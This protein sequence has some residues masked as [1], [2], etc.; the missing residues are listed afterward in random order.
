MPRRPRS[1][2]AERMRSAGVEPPATAISAPA[3]RSALT[4]AESASGAVTT[5]SGDCS[6]V[7]KSCES[8]GSRAWESKTTRTGWRAASGSRAVRSGS[9]ARAVPIPTAIASESAR[10]RWTR[11]R[12]RSPEIQGESP[13]AVEVRP[14]SEIAILRVTRGSPV[15]ACLRKGWLSRR[16]AVASSPAASSTSTPP[17]RRMPGPRPAA[18]SVGSSEAITTH[19]IPTSR[20]A[21]VQG[22]WRPWCAQGSRVTYI[23]APAGSSPRRRQSSSAARSAC[24]SP[25]SA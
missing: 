20:I 4:R 3:S 8:R 9:S 6:I 17:S 22:G 14:S 24:K 10:Q 16:A 7:F 19:S 21:S 23:V 2:R 25:S 5:I 18:F 1:A 13:E 12:L 15:R 11:A